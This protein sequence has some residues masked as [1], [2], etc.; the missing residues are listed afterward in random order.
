MANHGYLNPFLTTNAFKWGHLVE[1]PLPLLAWVRTSLIKMAFE[2]L[3]YF[4]ILIKYNNHI[5]I[6]YVYSC[7]VH[8]YKLH[9]YMFKIKCIV[10]KHKIE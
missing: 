2:I 3:K 8:K 10:K 5:E 6:S 9:L 1:T 7:H 4:I